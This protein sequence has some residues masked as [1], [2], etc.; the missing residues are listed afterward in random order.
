MRR[1]VRRLVEASLVLSLLTAPALA[2][3]TD[4]GEI[5]VAFGVGIDTLNPPLLS[6][7]TGAGAAV[8]IF[9]GLFKIG[10]DGQ[11]APGLAESYVVSE[12]GLEWTLHLRQGVRFHDGTEFDAQA[13][14]ANLEHLFDPENAYARAGIISAID[15]WIIPDAHTIVLK[16]SRP[17]GPLAAHLTYQANLIVS[18]AALEQYGPDGIGVHPVGTGPY[19]VVDYTPG[20]RLTVERFD[21]YW[22]TRPHL[23]RISWINIPEEGARVAAAETGS[24]DVAIPVSPAF[25]P[26]VDATPDLA[27]EVDLG[28]RMVFAALN[29]HVP[30]L[31]D[32]R[33]RE[34]MNLAIDREAILNALVPGVAVVPTSILQSVLF[35]HVDAYDYSLDLARAEALMSEAGWNRNS[36]GRFVDASGSAF[37]RLTFLSFRGR[38]T[39]DFEVAQAVHAQL[40]DFGL[41]IAFEEREFNALIAELRDPVN[42]TE[43][44][45]VQM[46]LFSLGTIWLDGSFSLDPFDSR[47]GSANWPY[48]FSYENEAVWPDLDE[49]WAASD[50]EAR[51]AAIARAQTAITLDHPIMPL[52]EAQ[53][54]AVV[55]KRL[56]GWYTL[57][58]EFYWFGDAWLESTQ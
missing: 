42:A 10:P 2:Q 17:F 18:P 49:A 56:Q 13:V 57:P 1:Y 11:V 51:R 54:T 45:R 19:R 4:G 55:N 8:H 53:Q 31:S 23:D 27:Y 41:D 14:A 12:D 47:A 20:G 26:I 35:G 52:Y 46:A 43:N 58:N 48:V 50:I 22:G 36:Q 28:G 34:A 6:S 25:R 5:T 9:E 40:S 7:L 21:E 44:A 24:I 38:V 30:A 33:V 15:S 3:P 29:T 32:V 16:L 39:G 37:P